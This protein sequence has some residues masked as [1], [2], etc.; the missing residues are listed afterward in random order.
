MY[1]YRFLVTFNDC[2]ELVLRCHKSDAIGFMH[3]HD[4]YEICMVTSGRIIHRTPRYIQ[5]LD[6]GNIM[7][8]RPHDRHCYDK[9]DEDEYEMFNL[10]M[11]R[12]CLSAALSWLYR[13]AYMGMI[14]G[15]KEPLEHILSNKQLYFLKEQ[16]NELI[17]LGYNQPQLKSL[18]VFLLVNCFTFEREHEHS[19]IPSW[20]VTV[21]REMQQPT[22]LAKG[23]SQLNALSG[24]TPSYVSRVIKK[25]YGITPTELVNNMRID[26]A[27]YLLK[28]T[29]K[30]V[31]DISLECGIDNLSHFYHLF[32]KRSEYSPARYRK[33]YLAKQQ[34]E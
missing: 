30:S 16:L 15:A 17:T 33:A 10:V 29:N 18:L 9:A 32:A 11:K 26:Y 14:D 13:G 23:L 1:R 8:I 20:I 2:D 22:N 4:Y 19:D 7:L 21:V 34:K 24:R 28:H 3:D 6:P 31:L 12:D 5:T 27:M 25:H